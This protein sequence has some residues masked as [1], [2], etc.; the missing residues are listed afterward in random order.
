[1]KDHFSYKAATYEDDKR[2]VDNVKQIAEAIASAVDLENDMHLLDFGS[3]TG[4]LLEAIAPRVRKITAVDVSPS[5]MAQLIAKQERLAC[6]LDTRQIDLEKASL[7]HTFD[8]IISSMTMHHIR[9]VPAMFNKF[10]SLLKPGGFVALA[11][12]DTEDG[13]FH[14]VDTGVHHTGFDRDWFQDA[15]GKAGF[16]DISMATTNKLIKPQGTYTVF[17][18]TGRK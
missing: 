15:L 2:R 10:H 3:G 1:M 12:L 11:D 5:M 8:G 4:L 16:K 17:L 18:C 14:D 13:S 9:D 6:E 7:E